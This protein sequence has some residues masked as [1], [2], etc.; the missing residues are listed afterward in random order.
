MENAEGRGRINRKED[1]GCRRSSISFKISLSLLLVLIPFLIILIFY[2]LS[3]HFHTDCSMT[4]CHNDHR[5][6]FH[7]QFPHR[8]CPQIFICDH[9]RALIHLTEEL[10]RLLLL[11]N[12][13]FYFSQSPPELPDFFFLFRSWLQVQIK[14]ARGIFIHAACRCRS[15]RSDRTPFSGRRRPHIVNH[16]VFN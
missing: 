12:I 1:R 15:C 4:V 9:F 8:F 7:F 11:Q 6:I 2:T 16:C 13:R 3:L 5:E 14:Q 10:R